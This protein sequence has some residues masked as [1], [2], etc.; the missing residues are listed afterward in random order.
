[1]LGK[2]EF[3][4]VECTHVAAR[5]SNTDLHANMHVQ[6]HWLLMPNAYTAI[7][8]PL[9]TAVLKIPSKITFS[10][11]SA[12]ENNIRSS[13]KKNSFVLNREPPF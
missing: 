4:L 12:Y 11:R 6:L 2:N 1:M 10:T 13:T 7:V 8:I 3:L 9:T 5:S